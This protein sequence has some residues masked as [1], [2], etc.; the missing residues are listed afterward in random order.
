MGYSWPK[1]I[2]NNWASGFQTDHCTYSQVGDGFGVSAVTV[3]SGLGYGLDILGI[4]AK[5]L[6]QWLKFSPKHLD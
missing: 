4:M 5:Y 2:Y 1:T 6:Q 3:I